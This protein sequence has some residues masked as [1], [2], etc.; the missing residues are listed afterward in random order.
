M[1]KSGKTLFFFTFIVMRKIS[2]RERKA[3]KRR[4][5]VLKCRVDRKVMI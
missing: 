5:A 1:E 4:M 2:V 3:D